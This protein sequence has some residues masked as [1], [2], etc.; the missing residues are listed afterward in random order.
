[1][2]ERIIRISVRYE[3][4][5]VIVDVNAILPARRYASA[6]ISYGCVCPSHAGIVSKRLNGF[7]LLFV[8]TTEASLDLSVHRDIMKFGYL[9]K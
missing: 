6:G 2:I 3:H 9:Q 7:S 4:T 5:S 1:L 8:Q